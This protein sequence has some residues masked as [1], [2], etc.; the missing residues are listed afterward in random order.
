MLWAGCFA[1]VLKRPPTG[2]AKRPREDQA[3]LGS[4]GG[5]GGDGEAP[6]LPIRDSQEGQEGGESRASLIGPQRA[7]LAALLAALLTAL[8]FASLFAAALP[9]CVG[10]GAFCVAGLAE[11]AVRIRGLSKTFGRCKVVDG[12]SLDLAEGEVLALLGPNGAG[13]TTAIAMLSGL[14]KPDPQAEENRLERDGGSV[15]CGGRAR[16]HP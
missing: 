9:F 2:G 15:G 16:T 12:L 5:G 6:R 10:T 8:I 4:R 7:V 14:L 11:A 13:K 1:S 3:G